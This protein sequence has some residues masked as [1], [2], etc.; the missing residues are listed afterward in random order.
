MNKSKKYLIYLSVAI[1]ITVGLATFMQSQINAIRLEFEEELE[2]HKE[3]QIENSNIIKSNK[4]AINEVVGKLVK[5]NQINE[6]VQ[7]IIDGWGDDWGIDIFEITFYAP[8]DNISGICADDNPS[9]T[10]TGT[11]PQPGTFA[12]DP[13]LI[14]YYSE[15]III[16]DDWIK[17]GKALDTGGAIRNPSGDLPKVDVYVNTYDEAIRRGTQIGVVVWKRD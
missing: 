3:L 15:M 17:T 12:V 9:V 1:L 5:T 7:V 14:P 11:Y 2:L 6:E 10:A 16:G 13:S 4:T 8:H